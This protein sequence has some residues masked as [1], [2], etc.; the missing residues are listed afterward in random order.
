MVL[1]K[2]PMRECKGLCNNKE[3]C[4]LPTIYKPRF[5]EIENNCL[6]SQCKCKMSLPNMY[7]PCCSTVLRRTPKNKN[8]AKP[9]VIAT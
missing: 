4:P 8:K 3:L 9:M 6:C 1:R 7:C 5:Y 2:L